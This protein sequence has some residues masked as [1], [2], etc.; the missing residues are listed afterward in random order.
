MDDGA[1]PDALKA[2][3]WAA[4]TSKSDRSQSEPI[5]REPTDVADAAT[6]AATRLVY[7]IGDLGHVTSMETPRLQ[8]GDCRYMAPELLNDDARDLQRA[9]VFSL[10]MSIYEL[11]RHVPLPKNGDEWQA[12]RAGQVPELDGY[13]KEF[14]SLLQVR[15]G[16]LCASRRGK[17][18]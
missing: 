8:D 10:G 16:A 2:N 7:K 13:S 5:L 3:R 11:A 6:P 17:G 12:L 1:I 4:P 14:N 9:D 18:R 15:G